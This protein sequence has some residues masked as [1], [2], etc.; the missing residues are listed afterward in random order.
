MNTGQMLITIGALMLLSL[1]ILRVNNNFLSTNTVLMEN[2]FGILAVSLG[3]SV[4][5][6]AKG[7]AFDHNTDTTAVTS[8]NQLSSIRPE[9]G[10]TDPLF[11]DFDDFDGL[12]R[13]DTTLPS[14]PFKIQCDVDYINPNNP[15]VASASKTWHKKLTVTVTSDFMQDTVTLSSIY[16]YFYFR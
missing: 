3:T 13:I 9:S 6:E 1:V 14:A 5:E 4:L 16:S 2:K 10:E 11:N 15:D 8:L 12:V 7:K